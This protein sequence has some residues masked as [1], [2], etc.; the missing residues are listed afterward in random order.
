M[1]DHE[2]LIGGTGPRL[3][4]PAEAASILN[5][6]EQ[7]VR[8]WIAADLIAYVT[9]PGGEQRIQLRDELH[10]QS[11]SHSGSLVS[12]ELT[13]GVD[14]ER[15]EPLAEQLRLRRRELQLQGLTWSN[16]DVEAL[17]GLL[18]ARLQEVVPDPGRVHVE[19]GMVW[20]AG[21]GIDVAQVV[22]DRDDESL[23]QRLIA[24]GERTLEIA[25]DSLSEVTSQPWPARS[26]QFA[27]GF[28]PYDARISDG[29]LHMRY[30]NPDAPILTLAPI[31]LSEI[32]LNPPRPASPSES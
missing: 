15:S 16:V 12:L 27:G 8:E 7:A 24:A 30:G 17:A 28:P 1:D 26:G 14:E 2:S 19:G 6:N 32:V 10:E 13:R 22:S 29:E 4:T 21:A 18:A 3:I 5:V 23:E 20:V 25:S 11:P 31:K 9:L